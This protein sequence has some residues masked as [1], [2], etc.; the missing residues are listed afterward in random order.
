MGREKHL[1]KKE[2]P[3]EMHPETR[4]DLCHDPAPTDGVGSAG[5]LKNASA[6]QVS[7]FTLMLENLQEHFLS[8]TADDVFQLTDCFL[9]CYG[10]ET[11][12][13]DRQIITIY[14]FRSA[15]LSHI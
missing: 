6:L 2:V 13:V 4:A 5:G 15:R 7:M 9:A 8:K 12:Q 1:S 11:D 14:G 10:E 3:K